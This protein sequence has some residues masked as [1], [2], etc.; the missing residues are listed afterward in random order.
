M[1]HDMYDAHLM[2]NSTVPQPQHAH[3]QGSSKQC[4]YRVTMYKVRKCDPSS[5]HFFY[6]FPQ[7]FICSR[8]SP[9]SFLKFFKALRARLRD[10]MH[11][12]Q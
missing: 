12:F 7:G 10:N 11:V 4:A 5:V 6:V 8:F 1:M 3:H 2:L 9:G